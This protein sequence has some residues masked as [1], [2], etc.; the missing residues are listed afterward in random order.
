MGAQLEELW[1]VEEERE[2]HD[3][4]H[5]ARDA[6][7]PGNGKKLVTFSDDDISARWR[8]ESRRFLQS[9]MSAVRFQV[10]SRLLAAFAVLCSTSFHSISSLSFRAPGLCYSLDRVDN[11]CMQF[12]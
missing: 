4:E 6:D 9:K 2:E 12:D 11:V 1:Q 8:R 5:V 10:C 3:G 7:P